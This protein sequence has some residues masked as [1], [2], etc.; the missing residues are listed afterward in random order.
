MISWRD[1]KKLDPTIVIET[2]PE[3]E[4]WLD[5]LG[6]EDEW[7]EKMKNAHLNVELAQKRI[8]SEAVEM[9]APREYELNVDEWEEENER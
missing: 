8:S 2:D 4:E 5:K 1:L 6:T 7:R 9:T 3:T